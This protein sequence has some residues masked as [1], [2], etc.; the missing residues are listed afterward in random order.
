MAKKASS[1]KK[2]NEVKQNPDPHIDQDFP[3]FPH[4]PSQKKHITPNTNVEKKEAGADKKKKSK[5]TYGS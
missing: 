3:G 1:I 2:E 4:A 5:K